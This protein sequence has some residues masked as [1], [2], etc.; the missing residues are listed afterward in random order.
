MRKPFR[1]VALSVFGCCIFGCILGWAPCALAAPALPGKIGASAVWQLPKQFM[2]SAHA[3]CDKSASSAFAE[4]FI[5][6]MANA[7]ASADA[8]SFTRELY[9]Q[10]HGDVGILTGL[11]PVGPVDIAWIIYPLR[12]NTN[13]G[14]LFIN[15]PEVNRDCAGRQSQLCPYSD[16]WN[17]VACLIST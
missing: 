7:G 14:L 5:N 8:V 4:C 3:A 17:K 16:E 15:G 1:F 10:S 2:A 13:N 9:K 6:Q 12:A 11:Q